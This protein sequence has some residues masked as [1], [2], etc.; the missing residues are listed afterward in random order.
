MVYIEIVVG[1]V[2]FFIEVGEKIVF[3]GENI[4]VVV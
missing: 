2:N 4:V 3:F 1:V